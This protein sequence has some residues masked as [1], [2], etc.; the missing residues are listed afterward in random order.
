MGPQIA[1]FFSNFRIQ[2]HVFVFTTARIS[3]M[4]IFF[5]YL[6]TNILLVLKVNKFFDHRLLDIILFFSTVGFDHVICWVSVR[7]I[8]NGHIFHHSHRQHVADTIQPLFYFTNSG[9]SGSFELYSTS[10]HQMFLFW[11]HHHRIPVRLLATFLAWARVNLWFCGVGSALAA[12]YHRTETV[13]DINVEKA[14]SL[15]IA[16]GAFLLLFATRW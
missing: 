2:K 1:K 9:N 13:H 15:L 4:K 3:K 8:S 7:I 11:F 10:T 5:V 12:A 14:A 6:Y 16:N